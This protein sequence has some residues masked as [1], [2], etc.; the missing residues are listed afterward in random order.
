MTQGPRS[1]DETVDVVIVGFGY[2]GGIAAIEAADAGA[3]VLLVEKMPDPGGI[4]V[5]SAGGVRLALD[6]DEALAYLKATNAGTTPDAVLAV[7]ARGMTM[8]A[9]QLRCLAGVS[10]ATVGIREAVGNY[11]FPGVDTFGFAT[12][13]ELPGFDAEKAFPQVRGS[14]FGARLFKVVADNV[15]ERRRISVRLATPA[16]RLVRDGD[17]AVL[18]VVLDGP[19]GERHVAAR[20]AVVLAT[21]GFEADGAMQAQFWQIKPV[22]SAA[23]RGNT[24]DGIR[25]AQAVGAGLWH[26]WHFHGSYGFRHP[27]PGY[28]FGIR[29]KR[30]PDWLPGKGPRGD[31]RMAWIMV[32]QTGRRFANEYHP[33]LQDTGH[34]P[35]EAFDPEIMRF[36]R[37]PAFMIVDDAGRRLY[38]L[39]APTYNDRGVRMSWSRDN[40]AEVA[41]GL[42]GRAASVA[43]VAGAI[44]VSEA[45][46]AD[47]LERWNRACRDGHDPEFGRAASTMVPIA[48]P[49]FY[50][51]PMWPIV[52]NTQ[53]GPVHD[54]R[55]RVLDAFGQVIPKLYAA[56]E[57]GSV[58]GHLYMSGGNLAECFIGGAIAGREAAAESPVGE[59]AA[60]D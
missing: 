11:P 48:T 21:G 22:L 10:G 38:P 50:Y 2:A 59:R 37:I 44:K 32:D 40:E 49:P 17:G 30:L 52:S 18:G 1:W 20:R 55:Q 16:K 7:L 14:I 31:V 29:T 60:A 45:A 53:G 42:I 25:M 12:I 9:D 34:R 58:F 13:D 57:L 36:P 33:Y 24:G 15:A 23:F 54:A 4:S 6:A 27:D 46:L 3:E 39:G 8:V 51:A 19:S 28:P 35:M 56:G 26:M 5:C 41:L 47:T 43:A